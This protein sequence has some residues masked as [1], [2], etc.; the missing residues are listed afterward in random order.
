MWNWKRSGVFAEQAWK[1]LELSWNEPNLADF[2]SFTPD[3]QLHQHLASMIPSNSIGT[4]RPLSKSKW[5]RKAMLCLTVSLSLGSRACAEQHCFCSL[6]RVLTK[7]PRQDCRLLCQK[8]L[9]NIMSTIDTLT[10]SIHIVSKTRCSI[11]LQLHTDTYVYANNNPRR[12]DCL[13]SCVPAHNKRL[14]QRLAPLANSLLSSASNSLRRFCAI[15]SADSP[16]FFPYHPLR[17]LGSKC[18]SPSCTTST[19]AS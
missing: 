19:A 10:S 1:W 7:S 14:T 15:T 11:M 9:R 8:I 3:P 16:V 2:W 17:L 6:D 12:V 4:Q 18:Q 5:R 13:P